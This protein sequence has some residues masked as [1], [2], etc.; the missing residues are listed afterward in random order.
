MNDMQATEALL[1]LQ[2]KFAERLH[3]S[4]PDS[5]IQKQCNDSIK[6]IK[7]IFSSNVEDIDATNTTQ[8]EFLSNLLYRY[9]A[10]NDNTFTTQQI[11]QFSA[12]FFHCTL[13]LGENKLNLYQLNDTHTIKKIF[14]LFQS[15]KVNQ[16]IVCNN[17][18]FSYLEQ[19]KNCSAQFTTILHS[20]IKHN[21]LIENCEYYFSQ[22][23]FVRQFARETGEKENYS[24]Y[25][26][27]SKGIPA[28][29]IRTSYFSE[30]WFYWAMQCAD[31]LSEK[32]LSEDFNS[33]ID[34]IAI[35]EKKVLLASIAAKVDDSQT[36]EQKNL[37]FKTYLLPAI[38]K[39]NPLH[40][41]Y[42]KVNEQLSQKYK[43]LLENAPKIFRKYYVSEFISIFFDALESTGGDRSRA[44]F[45]KKYKNKIY[46]FALG[47]KE[48]DSQKMRE[49][50]NEH[51]PEKSVNSYLEILSDFTLQ[52]R[53]PKSSSPA[54]LV[55]CFDS[56][57]IIEFSV[58]GNAVYIYRNNESSHHYY[59]KSKD[60]HNED[61]F[62]NKES[63][64]FIEAL[65]HRGYWQSNF[66]LR[67]RRIY[68]IEP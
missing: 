17:L 24:S 68:H 32:F 23:S 39:N 30:L 5:E 54:V 16:Q 27:F 9:L 8:S 12:W 56:V 61:D 25:L 19:H 15:D 66:G 52:L 20:H 53:I 28:R 6:K 50:I 37:Y 60:K 63:S 34:H 49:Y 4:W 13:P 64:D 31:V 10:Y 42:W 38:G 18:L 47:L 46:D 41:E 57:I 26:S 65:H 59:L 67:L 48:S 36:D 7:N 35:D 29:Y 2:R 33:R 21:G 22:K 3:Y 14:T 55:L 43:S 1:D 51:I 44:V 62:K 11:E 58:S 45:W 40:T